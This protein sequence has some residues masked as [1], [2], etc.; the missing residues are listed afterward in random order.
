MRLRQILGHCVNMRRQKDKVSVGL[1]LIHGRSGSQSQCFTGGRRDK[2]VLGSLTSDL[3]SWH[4]QSVA[5]PERRCCIYIER[6]TPTQLTS[7][8]GGGRWMVWGR[9]RDKDVIWSAF[10]FDKACCVSLLRWLLFP[11]GITHQ[12]MLF[13]GGVVLVWWTLCCSTLVL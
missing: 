8:P 7:H 3:T 11:W 5:A 9:Q 4:M 2:A 12:L 13:L 10:S 6:E 1:E